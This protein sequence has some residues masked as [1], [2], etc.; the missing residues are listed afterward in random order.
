MQAIAHAG[1]GCACFSSPSLVLPARLGRPF[2][3]RV[4]IDQHSIVP[5]HQL[6]Q[7]SL[8]IFSFFFRFVCCVC[9]LVSRTKL[10]LNRSFLFALRHRRGAVAV[11]SVA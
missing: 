11:S 5:L 10:N 3:A 4:T 1:C 9:Y 6:L 2:L 7:S 8:V